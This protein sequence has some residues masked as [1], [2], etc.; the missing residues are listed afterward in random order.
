[1]I[2]KS[3]VPQMSSVEFEYLWTL[4]RGS[5]SKSCPQNQVQETTVNLLHV[6][7]VSTLACIP[8]IDMKCVS[9]WFVS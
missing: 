9:L 5:I 4:C 8:L 3:R 2:I 6:S 1:M 7:R